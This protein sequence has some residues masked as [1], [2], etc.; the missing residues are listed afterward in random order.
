MYFLIWDR[1]ALKVRSPLQI[2]PPSKSHCSMPSQGS[3]GSLSQD[4]FHRTSLLKLDTNR[5]SI[6]LIP[7]LG[8]VAAVFFLHANSRV[9]H[10]QSLSLAERVRDEQTASS[11]RSPVAYMVSKACCPV[12]TVTAVQVDLDPLILSIYNSSL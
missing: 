8:H 6:H 9:S 5:F 3:R 2:I 10:F 11:S 7:R 1:F 12:A 4:Y